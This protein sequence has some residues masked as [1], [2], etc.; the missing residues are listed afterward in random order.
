MKFVL[1]FLLMLNSAFAKEILLTESN[2]VSLSG[3]VTSGYVGDLMFDLSELSKKG[4][5]KDPIYLVL[6]TPGGSVMA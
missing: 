4:D 5:V 2:T 6:N 1:L 3:P